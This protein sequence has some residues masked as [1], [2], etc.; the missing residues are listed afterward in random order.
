MKDTKYKCSRTDPCLFFKWDSSW[1]FRMWLTW[2]DNMLCIANMKQV[3]HKKELLE[4]HFKCDDVYMM[5]LH[6]CVVELSVI[7]FL[8]MPVTLL[9]LYNHGIPQ[10]GRSLKTIQPVLLQS[11][12]K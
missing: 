2:I 4:K 7:T 3:E 1:G 8:H 9:P 10:D 6:I 12:T 11:L 5:F